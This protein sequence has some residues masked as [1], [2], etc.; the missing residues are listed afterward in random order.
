[1]NI[2]MK[3]ELINDLTRKQQEIISQ[4]GS[5]VFVECA[6]DGII[7]SVDL[8]QQR[9]M[10]LEKDKSSLKTALDSQIEQMSAMQKHNNEVY[11]RVQ[12]LLTC[13]GYHFERGI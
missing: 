13:T 1:M 8:F 2:R 7:C 4:A 10:E 5:A 9:I 11:C 6:F 12:Q 3:Q